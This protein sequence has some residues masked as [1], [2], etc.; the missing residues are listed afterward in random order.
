MIYQTNL[1]LLNGEYAILYRYEKAGEGLPMHGHS[2]SE[3]HDVT[4]TRGRIRVTID[5]DRIYELNP[6]EAVLLDDR[7]HE[8]EALKDNSSTFHRYLHGIPQ[9]YESLPEEELDVSYE[10]KL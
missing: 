9:G 5:G 1:R 10:S 8:I 6:G 4:C 2:R 7:A 3:Q